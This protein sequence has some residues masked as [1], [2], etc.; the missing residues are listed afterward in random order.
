MRTDLL[1]GQ[2]QAASCST[3]LPDVLP[4]ELFFESYRLY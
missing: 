3:S 2:A 1:D 4:L